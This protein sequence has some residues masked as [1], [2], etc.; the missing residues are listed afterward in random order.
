MR[1]AIAASTSPSFCRRYSMAVGRDSAMNS[2]RVRMDASLGTPSPP[3]GLAEGL[4]VKAPLKLRPPA[5]GAAAVGVSPPPLPGTVAAV[6]AA[7]CPSAAVHSAGGRWLWSLSLSIPSIPAKRSLQRCRRNHWL[8]MLS[9]QRK[10]CSR[11][12]SARPRLSRSAL[13]RAVATTEVGVCVSGSRSSSTSSVCFRVDSSRGQRSAS[14]PRSCRARVR[15]PR[16]SPASTQRRNSHLLSSKRSC[17]LASKKPG[18][19]DCTP[20]TTSC[21]SPSLARPRRRMVAAYCLQL[22]ARFSPFSSGRCPSGPSGTMMP[23]P[24]CAFT[25]KEDFAPSLVAAAVPQR[26]PTHCR[27]RSTA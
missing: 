25:G 18:S 11:V 22:S 20:S 14:G 16:A 1:L 17:G 10:T 15:A 21:T 24:E 19:R 5:P 13:C 2:M 26:R 23:L 27:G 4:L 9:M 6:A 7:G 3:L 12:G 8:C